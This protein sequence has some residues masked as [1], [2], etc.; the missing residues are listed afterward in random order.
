MLLAHTSAAE[1]EIFTDYTA[2]LKARST[3]WNL[4]KDHCGDQ[5]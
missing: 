1:A 2:G 4:S 5:D 3:L